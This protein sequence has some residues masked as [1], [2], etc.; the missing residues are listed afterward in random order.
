ME[1]ARPSVIQPERNSPSRIQIP[2]SGKASIYH[3]KD[4]IAKI[5][6]MREK[7]RK[8][9]VNASESI[10]PEEK[11]R[12]RGAFIAFFYE[13]IL[14]VLC[15]SL[16]FGAV[17]N[18][19]EG[20]EWFA[21]FIFS[22]FQFIW[23]L[24]DCYTLWGS[25]EIREE[26]REDEHSGFLVRVFSFLWSY[27]VPLVSTCFSAIHFF[28]N[29]C[30]LAYLQSTIAHGPPPPPG[31]PPPP[32]LETPPSIDK[33][34]IIAASVSLAVT[35]LM[36]LLG[37]CKLIKKMF[38]CK[39]EPIEMY[40]IYYMLELKVQAK[41]VMFSNIDLELQTLVYVNSWKTLTED[42]EQFII[43]I[44]YIYLGSCSNRT[45]ASIVIVSLSFSILSSIG[46]TG[47]S[48]ISYLLLIKKRISFRER[49]EKEIEGKTSYTIICLPANRYMFEIVREVLMER[50]EITE[51]V[52]DARLS[53]NYALRELHNSI[54]KLFDRNLERFELFIHARK[55][56]EKMRFYTT[57]LIY[58]QRIYR[59]KLNGSWKSSIRDFEFNE[60]MKSLETNS[61]LKSIE[62]C[63]KLPG[64]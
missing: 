50:P 53:T 5:L 43:Q 21:Y 54:I 30:F 38:E 40:Q 7:R 51:L 14:I 39:Y 31:A 34:L 18:C 4:A 44:L 49:M 23:F 55:L 9:P 61:F 19:E 13:I 28:L 1:L 47:S 63:K 52:I 20:L 6:K 59:I 11:E 58:N 24:Y 32:Q 48:I 27:M 64:Y 26:L 60:L 36:K 41:K 15:I 46:L 45:L 37:F 33:N 42:I 12:R 25:K 10:T 16:P 2:R 29:F 17:I 3:G 62:F 57:A 22:F 8:V 56:N 35:S